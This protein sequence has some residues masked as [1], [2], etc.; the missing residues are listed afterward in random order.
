MR[1]G[2][3]VGTLLGGGEHMRLISRAGIGLLIA[4]GLPS[5]GADEDS[6]P[7]AP[8][9]PNQAA[10]I[11]VS[12]PRD[13]VAPRDTLMLV[14]KV[15][16]AAG[17]SLTAAAV[18]WTSSDTAVATVSALG[19][20]RA[21][22]PGLV[23]IFAMSG[24]RS[25]G[26]LLTVIANNPPGTPAALAYSARDLGTLGGRVSFAAAINDSGIVVGTSETAEGPFYHAFLW[27]QGVMTDLGTDA[28]RAT[29]AADINNA[30]V[31][32]GARDDRLGSW[33]AVR[34]G[35]GHMTEL[36]SLGGSDSRATGIN[37]RGDIVGWSTLP[38]DP[39]PP[40]P[41]D[42]PEETPPPITHAVLW[43]DGTVLDLG[44]LS[45]YNSRAV[46]IS[47]RGEV[48]GQGEMSDGIPH[49][50]LWRDGVML[51]LGGLE[52]TPRSSGA[53]AVNDLGIVVGSSSPPLGGPTHAF[54]YDGRALVDLGTLGGYTYAYPRDINPAG[55]IVGGYN[56]APSATFR[57]AFL[58]QDG[59]LTRLPA[60]GGRTS[61]ALAINEDGDIVG[62]S[63]TPTAWI[64]HATLWT[65][66]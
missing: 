37:D 15:T 51:D 47:D 17:L 4:V 66:Q 28:P 1:A 32:V 35:D 36:P 25:G 46:D 52:P 62:T 33:H 26:H 42:D 43:R 30:G 61:E 40:G 18:V 50:F 63:E 39:H 57:E 3:P 45:G 58:Y 19:L 64:E 10:S 34:W 16:D 11:E 48:V 12:A 5:C 13:T 20:V 56:P 54:W 49:A 27:K 65:R 21:I 22:G 38:G 41:L 14:A 9:P 44:T 23:E 60:V 24:G 29:S 2:S 55:W 8:S 53:L 7:S 59:R 6:G 31:V